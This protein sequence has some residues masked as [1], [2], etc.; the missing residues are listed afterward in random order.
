VGTGTL[1]PEDQLVDGPKRSSN[2]TPTCDSTGTV[3]LHPEGLP[4]AFTTPR[5]VFR[6][7]TLKGRWRKS[8]NQK[9]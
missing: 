4:S 9:D 8:K 1:H 6:P 5:F 2:R 7:R 3:I